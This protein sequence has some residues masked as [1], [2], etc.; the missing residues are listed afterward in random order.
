MVSYQSPLCSLNELNSWFAHAYQEVIP[1]FFNY[2]TFNLA[3]A[4]YVSEN[5]FYTFLQSNFGIAC[6]WFS[7]V[8]SFVQVKLLQNQFVY[9][10]FTPFFCLYRETCNNKITYFYLKRYFR[11]FPPDLNFSK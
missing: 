6:N 9:L 2:R 7:K 5:G 8:A 10:F 11:Y 3:C 1:N 4:M